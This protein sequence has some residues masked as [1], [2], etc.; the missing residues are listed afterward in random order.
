[1]TNDLDGWRGQIN[2][3]DRQ[4]LKTLEARFRVVEKIAEYKKEHGLPVRDEQRETELIAMLARETSLS[5]EFLRE[6]YSAIFAYSY[7]IEQ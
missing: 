3:L 6:L 5:P 7:L 2:E 1:M 4:L